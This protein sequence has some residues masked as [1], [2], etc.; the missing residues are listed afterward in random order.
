MHEHEL[1]KKFREKIAGEGLVVVKL[2]GKKLGH[3]TLEEIAGLNREIAKRSFTSLRTKCHS[4]ETRNLM[5]NIVLV[6]G[7]GVQIDEMM[8]KLGVEPKTHDGYRITN[9][10]TMEVV[11]R[12]M[13]E[14]GEYVHGFLRA[15]GCEAELFSNGVF[16]AES[17]GM[18]WDRYGEIT[19]LGKGKVEKIMSALMKN[20]VVVLSP[21][22]IDGNGEPLNLDADECAAHAAVELGAG[23]ALLVTNVDGIRVDG[24]VLRKTSASMLEKMLRE[25][26]VHSGMIPKAKACIFA[27]TH[28]VVV[29][30]INGKILKAA[31]AHSA[32]GKICGTVALPDNLY[33]KW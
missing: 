18:P 24:H 1:G 25:G 28:G 26:H 33:K 31:N 12:C 9:R 27:T 14:T 19:G 32:N 15:K 13:K 30:I 23:Q 29:K 3:E 17:M 8:R 5:R 20:R 16:E 6:H 7:G 22:G 2:S 10:T 21:V 11:E 4:H